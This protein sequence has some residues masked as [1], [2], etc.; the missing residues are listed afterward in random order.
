MPKAA[1]NAPMRA[2]R[3]VRP[4]IWAFISGNS[5]RQISI[6]PQMDAAQ[7]SSAFQPRFIS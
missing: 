4:L 3:S 7:M 2:N 6:N 1:V 5:I